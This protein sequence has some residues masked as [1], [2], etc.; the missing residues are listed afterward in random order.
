MD[1]GAG[2]RVALWPLAMITHAG[3]AKIMAVSL[4][5]DDMR[6]AWRELRDLA[7]GCGVTDATHTA[8]DALLGVQE[9]PFRLPAA[10]QAAWCARV[11][12]R[13]VDA[14]TSPPQ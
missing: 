12:A 11:L 3:A 6:A 2:A 5:E 13:Y 7:A 4:P 14:H 10:E 1:A 8:P 9:L